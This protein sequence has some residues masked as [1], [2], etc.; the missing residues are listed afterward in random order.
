MNEVGKVPENRKK[1]TEQTIESA[2]QFFEVRSQTLKY[3]HIDICTYIHTYMY[4]DILRISILLLFNH[5]L[6]FQRTTNM[7]SQLKA[8]TKN[9]SYKAIVRWWKGRGMAGSYGYYATSVTASGNKHTYT[10][11]L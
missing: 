8:K 9:P 1:R 7:G 6:I 11:K 5:L 10:K 2:V 4:I 3:R